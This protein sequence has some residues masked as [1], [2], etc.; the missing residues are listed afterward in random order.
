METPELHISKRNAMFAC[1]LWLHVG[2]AG[3]VLV[4]IELHRLF[5]GEAKW[6]S[7]MALIIGGCFMAAASWRRSRAALEEPAP[8]SAHGTDGLSGNLRTMSRKGDCAQVDHVVHAP[9]IEV[10]ARG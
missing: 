7:A 6:L 4:A 9:A 8:A 10:K 1:C 3:A 2:F 5:T